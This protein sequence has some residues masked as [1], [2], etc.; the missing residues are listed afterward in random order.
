LHTG[1]LLICVNGESRTCDLIIFPQAGEA[2][3]ISHKMLMAATA[4]SLIAFPAMAQTTGTASDKGPHYSGGPKSEVPYHVG[5]KTTTGSNAKAKS[6]GGSH[7][8]TGGP[9]ADPHHIGPKN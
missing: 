5:P 2:D 8:Y 7:H 9:R 1:A 6:G 4:A 3:M